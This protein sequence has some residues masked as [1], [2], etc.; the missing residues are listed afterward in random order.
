M[1]DVEKTARL[2]KVLSVGS[3]V[4]MVE[5]LKERSLCVNALAKT[6]GITAAAVSQHLRVLRDVGLVNPEKHGYYV[7]YRINR[8]VLQEWNEIASVLLGTSNLHSSN[9][10]QSTNKGAEP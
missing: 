3:R 1:S 4:R 7:H 10:R 9:C 8:E 6:L 2:F 5:L